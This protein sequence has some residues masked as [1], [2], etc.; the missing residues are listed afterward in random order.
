MPVLIGS[1]ASRPPATRGFVRRRGGRMWTAQLEVE[2]TAV[3]QRMDEAV[4]LGEGYTQ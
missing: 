1:F 3:D 2:E 4:V